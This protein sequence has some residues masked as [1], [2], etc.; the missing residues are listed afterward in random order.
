MVFARDGQGFSSVVFARDGQGFSSVVF[1]GDGQGFS[2]VVFAGD[3]HYGRYRLRGRTFDE[4]R[5]VRAGSFA[6]RFEF[7]V[8]GGRIGGRT[9]PSVLL[10]LFA[11]LQTSHAEGA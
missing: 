4:G 3:G 2:S 5:R 9:R 1:A 6:G 8:N 10:V 11:R 7:G